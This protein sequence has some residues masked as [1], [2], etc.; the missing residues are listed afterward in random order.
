MQYGV[1][2]GSV[3]F[4]ALTAVAAAG[5]QDE[6]G[7]SPR[8]PLSASLIQLI[9]SPEKYHGKYVRVNG[10]VRIE[11]EGTAIYLHREDSDH[12]LTRNGLWLGGVRETPTP[13]SDEG[14]V[15][16]RYALIEGRF[17]ARQ[18]GHLG[19]WSGS[20]DKVSRMIPWEI[21]KKTD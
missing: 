12:M 19:L 13:D 17:D 1:L 21:P 20:I 7:A 5:P 10:F 8:R 6:E 9:A 15:H 4:V 16:N 14:K 3:L 18:R 11:H 2:L